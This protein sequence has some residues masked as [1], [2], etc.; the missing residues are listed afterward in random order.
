MKNLYFLSTFNF[1]MILLVL[2][3]FS[4]DLFDSI[5]AGNLTK[6]KLLLKAEP[7]LLNTTR[8]NGDT[9]L[10][11]AAYAGQRDIVLYLLE[12][13]VPVNQ[14]NKGNATALLYAVY[15]GHKEIAEILLDKGADCNSA[16]FSGRTSLH[17]AASNGRLD[18]VQLLLKNGAEIDMRAKPYFGMTPLLLA[19]KNNSN[20]VATYLIEMGADLNDK[21]TSGWSSLHWALHRECLKLARIIISKGVNIHLTD[22]DGKTPIRMAVEYGYEDIVDFLYK[23]G[24]V[25]NEREKPTM[26]TLLHSAV[27]NGYLNIAAMLITEGADVN[28]KDN[29]GKTPLFY[30]KKYGHGKVGDLL[31]IHGATAEFNKKISENVVSTES[32]LERGEAIIWYLGHCGWAI[33]TQNHFLIFDYWQHGNEPGEASLSNG[34]INPEEMK[35]SQVY[36][37]VSH[38]H[39]DHFDPIIFE[40]E[41]RIKNIKYILGWQLQDRQ[42]YLY[43][44]PGEPTQIDDLYII[45]NSCYDGGVPNLGFLINV[46]GIVMYHSGDDDSDNLD[47]ITK[48]TKQLDLFFQNINRNKGE[49]AIQRIESLLPEVALPMH[50]GEREYRY[51]GFAKLVLEKIPKVNIFCAENRGDRF[52][53]HAK[54]IK[55]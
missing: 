44:K 33:K 5:E 35:N 20:D 17:H 29:N 50:F 7:N 15:F 43:I 1:L 19:I 14:T 36:V 13:N 3:G 11:F 16:D 12:H 18:I 4:Q 22:S 28:A 47:I 45:T 8:E 27:I 10:H 34:H 51:K 54:R 31:E 32:K 24:A 2:P 21:D 37:F 42:N 9:P 41:K 40:W 26:R 49:G 30:T 23:H 48:N 25:L 55:K 39:Y 46:D 6:V 38:E 53:Y 52:F